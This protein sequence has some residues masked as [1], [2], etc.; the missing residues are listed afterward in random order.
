MLITRGKDMYISKFRHDGTCASDNK[1][2][3]V[4]CVPVIPSMSVKHKTDL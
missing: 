3:K 4:G 2:A 1:P